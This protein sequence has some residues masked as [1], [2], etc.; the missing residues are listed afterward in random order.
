MARADARVVTNATIA[1]AVGDGK[2]FKLV[3]NI[4]EICICSDC[5]SIYRLFRFL[6]G[7]RLPMQVSL[8]L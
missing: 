8:M 6:S 4:Q 7:G 5:K 2:V 3:I 1:G